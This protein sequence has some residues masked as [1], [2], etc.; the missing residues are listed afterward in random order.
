[1]IHKER[2]IGVVVLPVP[3]GVSALLRDQFSP[4]GMGG[5]A[6]GPLKA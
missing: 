2:I 6:L 3:S 4:R 1:M 5:E